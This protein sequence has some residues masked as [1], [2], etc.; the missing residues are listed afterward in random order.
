MRWKLN[1]GPVISWH[2]TSFAT[3]ERALYRPIHIGIVARVGK[4]PENGRYFI[5]ITEL[6]T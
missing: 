6:H 2:G 5:R 1:K 4:H 3:L